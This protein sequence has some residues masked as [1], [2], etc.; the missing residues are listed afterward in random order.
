M[1][2]VIAHLIKPKLPYNQNVRRFSLVLS[3]KSKSAYAWVRNK[4]SKRLPTIRTLRSWNSNSQ[5]NCSIQSGFNSQTISTL[6][7]LADENIA[8][9]KELYVSLSFDEIS[10]RKHVQWVHCEKRYSGLVNYG[11]KNDDEVPVANFAIFFLVTLVESGRSLILGYF[12]IKT[13]NTVEKTE[14]I[15]NSIQEITSTGCYLMSIA[16]DGL[17]TN[18]SSCKMLGASFDIEDFRP[19]ILNPANSRRICVVL[20]PPHC[21]KLI[22][23]CI[24]DKQNLRD[25]NN[26]PICWSFFECLVSQKSNLISHKMTR[27]HIEFHSNKMNVK[28]AAQTL[29]LS[30]AKSMEVLLRS[31]DRSFSNATGTII[32]VKNFN[33]AFD[34]FNA[35]H[36]DSNNLFKKGLSLESA[37]KIFEFL[38]YFG[39]YV[40]S[41]TYQGTNILKTARHTA[42]LG[43]L[44]NTETLR[45]FYD[46]FIFKK[47]IENIFFF[48]FGQD[49]LE[50]LFGRVRSML[51]L[52]TNPT[53]EQLSG[54]I[55]QLMNCDELKASDKANCQDQ[56]SIL[57]A[58][59]YVPINREN[60]RTLTYSDDEDESASIISNAPLNFKDMYT[61]KLRAGTIEKKIRYAVP[62]CTHEQ[63]ANIFRISSDKIDGIFYENG[64]AQRPTNSTVRI[65]EIVYKLLNFFNDISKF[66]YGKIYKKILDA[67]PFDYLYM[68]VDFSHNIEHKSQFIL[69]IVDE[70]IRIHATYNARLTTLQI[71]S[72][73]VGKSAQ[74]LKHVLGQ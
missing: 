7:K 67:I 69:L 56:L 13:L 9:G 43:F 62:R 10:I 70:Y 5:A 1:K 66:N 68:H 63:C 58:K 39:G 41:I 21:I 64:I 45:Y 72:K 34:I 8:A 55:R 18:F 14:L 40:K 52:N 29:S 11:K 26:N 35:K 71:H 50:S 19:F 61:I 22:R 31:G 49:L 28:I 20:D 2:D 60:R 25:G 23:G 30:V 46:E 51:G 24:A 3:I 32:F 44:I 53:T 38:D 16:F 48:F 27:R 17:S 37:Q 54:V 65:C 59:S 6:K 42:F 57:T 36:S 73:I 4:F 74:K 47:K 15:R 33:K 12:L